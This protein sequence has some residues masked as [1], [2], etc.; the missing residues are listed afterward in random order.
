MALAPKSSGVGAS[1]V[2]FRSE[3]PSS[4][5]MLEDLPEEL[6]RSVTLPVALRGLGKDGKRVGI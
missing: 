6:L 5:D 2:S 4:A 3:I 1:E